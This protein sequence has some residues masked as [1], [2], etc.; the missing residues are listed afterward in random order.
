VVDHVA[1]YPLVPNCS[2]HSASLGNTGTR[3]CF[4]SAHTNEVHCTHVCINL[5]LVSY[6]IYMMIILCHP[7]FASPSF[8]GVI[9]LSSTSV[10]KIQVSMRLSI[11]FPVLPILL[12]PILI[13]SCT[14]VPQ[15][16]VSQ[17][18]KSTLV[19]VMVGEMVKSRKPID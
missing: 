2:S 7:Q 19:I 9:P 17:C 4:H 15:P 10:R 14:A 16:E 5:K 12:I 11:L 6:L 18:Q 8:V 3:S 1:F 13:E